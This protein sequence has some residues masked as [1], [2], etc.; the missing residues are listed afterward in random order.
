[1]KVH[2]DGMEITGPTTLTATEVE[3]SHDHRIAMSF[4]IAGLVAKGTTQIS[5]AESIQT[6]YPDFQEHLRTLQGR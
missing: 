3:A 6:S 2:E 5:G 4:A 1:V